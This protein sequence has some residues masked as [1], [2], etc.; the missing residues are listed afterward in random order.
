MARR[1][2]VA[3]AAA[4]T[5]AGAIVCRPVTP[6]R[7]PDLVRLFGPRGACAGC[8]C[9]WSRLSA[10]EFERGKGERNRRALKR[11]VDAGGPVGLLA[12]MDGEPAGWCAVAPREQYARLARSRVL[13]P[14]DER[15]AWSVPCFFVGRA[16]RGRGVGRALLAAAVAFARGRGAARVEGYPLDPRGKRIADV[17]AWFGLASTFEAAGFREVA[18]RSPTRPIMRRELRPARRTA[19]ASAVAG[20]RRTPL[21]RARHG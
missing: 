17:W 11:L 5:A 15:P 13:A 8:W 20:P 21:P 2:T 12:Y 18:R 1:T 3:R 14:V 19:S 4:S 16:H 7:W 10:A 9:M 6:A